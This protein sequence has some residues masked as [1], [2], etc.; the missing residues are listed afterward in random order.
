MFQK[1]TQNIKNKRH[2]IMHKN[3]E[4]KQTHIHAYIKYTYPYMYTYTH[5]H[6]YSI[7]RHTVQL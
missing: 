7:Y 1:K 6:A 5:A 2:K 4:K 3:V